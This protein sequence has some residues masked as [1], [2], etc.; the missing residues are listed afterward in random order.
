MCHL[1][2][3]APLWTG[4][5]ALLISTVRRDQAHTCTAAALACIVYQHILQL[6]SHTDS[7]AMCR[8][9]IHPMHASHQVAHDRRHP[10]HAHRAIIE[11][12][13]SLVV[14]QLTYLWSPTYVEMAGT[15]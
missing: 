9:H 5:A 6:C 7:V 15:L 10:N 13:P 4:A 12:V 2:P 14:V 8:L 1:T 3:T 11:A